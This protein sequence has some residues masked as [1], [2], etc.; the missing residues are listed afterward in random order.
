MEKYIIK[1]LYG[2]RIYKALEFRS[3]GSAWL[4]I[5]QQLLKDF[6]DNQKV[7]EFLATSNFEDDLA[8]YEVEE[9][10]NPI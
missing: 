2:D 10:V 8:Y 1:N 6:P 9:V 7:L 4:F 3:D 5:I